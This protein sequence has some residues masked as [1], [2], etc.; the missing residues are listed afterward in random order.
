LIGNLIDIAAWDERIPDQWRL[1]TGE[2]RWLGAIPPQYIHPAPVPIRR[3]PLA[4]LQGGCTGLCV[5]TR[6][7][8]DVR[9]ILSH[10]VG[11]TTLDHESREHRRAA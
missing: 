8:A 1:R 10:C 3:S 9:M 2:G 6:D 7:P 5:I 4:W 11:G